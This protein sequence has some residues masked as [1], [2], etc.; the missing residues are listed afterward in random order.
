M[1]ILQENVMLEG[2]DKIIFFSK[3]GRLQKEIK[4]KTLLLVQTIP[5]KSNFAVHRVRIIDREKGV[6]YNCIT[7]Y[8]PEMEEIKDLY[9][10]KH[11]YEGQPPSLKVEML[12]DIPHFRVYDDKIFIEESA[13]G[14]IIEVFA[15]QGSKLYQINNPYEKI[16]FTDT[17]KNEI[18]DRFKSDPLVKRGGGWERFSKTSK[19]IFPDTFPAIK[20]FE[21]S[22]GRI[23]IRTYKTVED[24][25]EYVV[26]DLK[27]KLIKKVYLPR[28][29]ASAL[30]EEGL[31]VKLYSIQKDKLYYL[32]ENEEKECW[33]LYVEDI[34]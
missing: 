7:L 20:D 31:G 23:H 26:T 3:Q 22:S 13:E 25:V 28:F 2:L 15:H 1:V 33:D 24:K 12:M 34:K 9:C 18:I 19:M 4:K 21:I 11:F 10:M 8:N 5:I 14:F 32:Q 27:G 17:H 6:H 29:Q 30:F 16:K